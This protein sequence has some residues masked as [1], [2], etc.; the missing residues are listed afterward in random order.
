MTW[1]GAILT[2][3]VTGDLGDNV[4]LLVLRVAIDAVVTPAILTFSQDGDTVTAEFASEP[5]LAERNA[6]DAEAAT[7]A[8][9]AVQ[10]ER[11]I[12]NGEINIRTAELIRDGTFTFAVKTFST[13]IASSRYF[14]ILVDGK[15]T[16]SYPVVVDTSG[17]L[18]DHS[19]ANATAVDGL[20]E[21]CADE[22]RSIED[23][24][25]AL[26]VT[27]RAAGTVAAVRAIVDNR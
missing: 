23:S 20:H 26:K 1:T 9:G 17:D 10:R 21:A 22:I 11:D 19:L 15:D 25:T 13:A 8:T 14:G 27:V 6:A 18:D 7:H 24:G 5:I 2:L 4:D 12:K 16:I 3:S